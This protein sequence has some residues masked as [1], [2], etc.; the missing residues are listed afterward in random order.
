MSEQ[1]NMQELVA[2]I[3]NKTKAAPASIEQVLKVEQ[4]FINN[5][6][7]DTNGEV[8]IDSDELVDY[9][10]SRPGIKLDEPTVEG[11][12]EAEMDYLMDKGIAG[13]ED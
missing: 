5:A 11:I 12:L 10:L 8:S 13:Y 3:A 6:P 4:D 7:E 9:I 1:I 2:F